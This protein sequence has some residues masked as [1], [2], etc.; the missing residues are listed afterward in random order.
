[1]EVLRFAFKL[2]YFEWMAKNN[3]DTKEIKLRVK[4]FRFE[5]ACKGM[6]K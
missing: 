3:R 5:E 1:M 4:I 2:I 6:L